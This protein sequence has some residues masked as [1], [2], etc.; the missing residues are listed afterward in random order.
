M[1]RTPTPPFPP[2]SRTALA[3]HARLLSWFLDAQAAPFGVHR[4]AVVGKAAGKDAAAGALRHIVF[5]FASAPVYPSLTYILQLLLLV[6]T[7]SLPW[8]LAVSLERRFT[9][10]GVLHRL[11]RPREGVSRDA[12]TT[13]MTPP[14]AHMTWHL[15]LRRK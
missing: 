3:L 5:P 7:L 8:A 6:F 14:F 15:V 1:L 11:V 10:I 13:T 2:Q 12:S 4:M 9:D